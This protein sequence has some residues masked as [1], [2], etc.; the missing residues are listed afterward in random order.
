VDGHSIHELLEAFEVPRNALP[1]VVIARTVKGKG[2]S[3]MENSLKWHGTPPGL[4]EYQAA[5]A[6]LL[7]KE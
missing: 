3:F 1:R 2:V 6:E 5:R 4:E 7:S